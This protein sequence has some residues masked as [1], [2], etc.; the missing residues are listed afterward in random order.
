[1]AQ[2]GT[3]LKESAVYLSQHGAQLFNRPIGKYCSS[4]AAVAYQLERE[5]SE[6]AEKAFTR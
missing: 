4:G 1:M 5:R 6:F 2:Q 3:K